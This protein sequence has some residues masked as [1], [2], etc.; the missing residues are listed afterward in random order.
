MLYLLMLFTNR[1]D[2][3]LLRRLEMKTENVQ[4]LKK[5]RR[6]TGDFDDLKLSRET[7]E[8]ELESEE[9]NNNIEK[10]KNLTRRWRGF[11]KVMGVITL[12]G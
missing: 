10:Y 8:E 1:A 4:A 9:V 2:L 11:D 3:E 6:N 12:R 7:I 5:L